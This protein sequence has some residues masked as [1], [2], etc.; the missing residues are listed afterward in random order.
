MVEHEICYGTMF[1]DSWHIILNDS[2]Q[3]KVFSFELDTSG[4]TQTDKS[5]FAKIDER[6]DCLACHEFDH[7]Y[8]LCM[9]KLQMETAISGK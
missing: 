9:A 3:G 8:K 4:L 2:M 6:D 1:H 5:I 7:C